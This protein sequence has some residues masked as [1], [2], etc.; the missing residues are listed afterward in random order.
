MPA[1]SLPQVLPCLSAWECRLIERGIISVYNKEIEAQRSD[2][3]Y[4]WSCDLQGERLRPHRGLVALS[5]APFHFSQ[6]EWGQVAEASIEAGT[7]AA[8]AVRLAQA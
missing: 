3:T 6:C 8:A 4:P 1:L 5:P 2:Q 7:W